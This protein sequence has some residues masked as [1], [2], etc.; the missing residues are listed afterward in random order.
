MSSPP[1]KKQRSSLPNSPKEKN[2][3]EESLWEQRFDELCAFK[4][5]NGHCNV[6]ALDAHTN[7]LG[8]WVMKQRASFKT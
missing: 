2:V 6:S 3:E 5:Q 4:A 8:E 1:R 7:S